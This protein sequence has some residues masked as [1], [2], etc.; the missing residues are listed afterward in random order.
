[1]KDFNVT[2]EITDSKGF[3]STSTTVQHAADET[4][5][6][7]LLTDAWNALGPVVSDHATLTVTSVEP[8]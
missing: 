5:A 6:A 7:A 1:M 8:A 2:A 4:A 3:T